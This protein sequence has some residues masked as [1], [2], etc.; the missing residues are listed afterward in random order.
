MYCNRGHYTG[1]VVAKGAGRTLLGTGNVL[2]LDSRSLFH[3]YIN[4]KKINQTISMIYAHLCNM[5]YS[6][7]DLLK[8]VMKDKLKLKAKTD[9]AQFKN[10]LYL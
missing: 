9:K 10:L 7:K 3:R 6:S 2:F 1:E 8:N 5:L 4:L